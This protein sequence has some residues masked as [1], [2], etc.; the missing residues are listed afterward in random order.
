MVAAGCLRR[1]TPDVRLAADEAPV[2]S[3]TQPPFVRLP[4]HKGMVHRILAHPKDNRFLIA[5]DLKSVVLWNIQTKERVWSYEHGVGNVPTLIGSFSNSGETFVLGSFLGTFN[6]EVRRT[7]D[8]TVLRSMAKP[9]GS[10]GAMKVTALRYSD[11][12]RFLLGTDND[13]GRIYIWNL[14]NGEI[15]RTLRGGDPFMHTIGFNTGMD[16]I[17]AV[18][19]SRIKIWNSTD[20]WWIKQVNP[21]PVDPSVDNWTPLISGAFLSRNLQFGAVTVGKVGGERTLQ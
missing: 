6:L 16:R 11:D 18:S 4:G 9:A 14:E 1:V 21:K 15:V 5:T 3:D 19:F 10:T 17:Y 8:G 13:L 20:D 2:V 7:S 12:D